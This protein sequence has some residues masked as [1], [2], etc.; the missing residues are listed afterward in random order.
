MF[1]YASHRDTRKRYHNPQILIIIIHKKVSCS[2]E[3]EVLNVR[4]TQMLI[5]GQ[6]LVVDQPLNPAFFLEKIL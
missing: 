4:H 1:I 6:W 2:R 5:I 3:M